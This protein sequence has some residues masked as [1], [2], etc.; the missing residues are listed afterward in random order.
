MNVGMFKQQISI[1]ENLKIMSVFLQ[2]VQHL[3]R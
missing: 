3:V 1:P 2:N